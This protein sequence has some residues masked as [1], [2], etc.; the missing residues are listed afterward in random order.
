MKNRARSSSWLTYG[1]GALA[2]ALVWAAASASAL[3]AQADA[4]EEGHAWVI[5][6]SD[7]VFAEIAGS[8]SER[9]RGLMNRDEVPPGTGML[10]TFTSFEKRTFWMKDTYVD[11]DLAVLDEQNRVAE[12]LTMTAESLTLHDTET[13]VYTALEVPAGW[14]AA[15]GIT[16]GAQATIILGGS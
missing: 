5:F 6:G 14:F 4:P 16:V 7:T 2:V 8:G 10:F 3:H 13:V 9:S 11:L 1:I 15:N 12:I